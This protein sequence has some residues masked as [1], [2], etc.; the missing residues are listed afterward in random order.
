MKNKFNDSIIINYKIGKNDTKIKIF[1]ENFVKNNKNNCHIIYKNKK[2]EL[3]EY[4]ELEKLE[5]LEFLEIKLIG[6][7]N[8]IDA[9]YM[10][11]ECEYLISLPNINIWNTNNIINMSWMF[12]GCIY[13]NL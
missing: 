9:S 2:Y 6:I 12:R 7:N 3:M 4:L 10:F 11:Y 1:G 8:I 5:K 13:V